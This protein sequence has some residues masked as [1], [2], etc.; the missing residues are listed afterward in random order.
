[1]SIGSTTEPKVGIRQRRC[2]KINGNNGIHVVY[3]LW[4]QWY[5]CGISVTDLKKK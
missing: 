3:Q 5:S 1:M 2:L 4:R